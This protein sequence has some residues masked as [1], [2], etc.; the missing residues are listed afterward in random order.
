[1]LLA[2]LHFGESAFSRT[3]WVGAADPD[4]ALAF[5]APA[6]SDLNPYPRAHGIRR[7]LPHG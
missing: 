3:G 7:K 1:V 4:L 5:E 6:A 2:E